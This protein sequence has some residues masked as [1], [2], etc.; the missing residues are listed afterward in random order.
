MVAAA[1]HCRISNA[2]QRCNSSKRFIILEAYYERFCEEYSN[3]MQELVVGDPMDPNTQLG[4]LATTSML[5]EVH[6]QVQESVAQ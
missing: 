2:G 1:V 4:P 5:H 6:R 3:Y